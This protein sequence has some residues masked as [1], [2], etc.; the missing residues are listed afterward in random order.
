MKITRDYLKQVIKEELE[1]L[2]E[3]FYTG[4]GSAGQPAYD[5]LQATTKSQYGNAPKGDRSAAAAAAYK[6][7]QSSDRANALTDRD[8]R[9]IDYL[10][11]PGGYGHAKQIRYHPETGQ[12]HIHHSY[13]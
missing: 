2:D 6:D 10:K 7:A 8:K 13:K 4:G 5:D 9:V 3:A 1:R 11:S 12:P